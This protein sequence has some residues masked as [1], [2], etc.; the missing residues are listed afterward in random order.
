VSLGAYLR[1]ARFGFRRLPG[2]TVLCRVRDGERP[3]TFV[4]DLIDQDHR[5]EQ[6]RGRQPHVEFRCWWE[7][8]RGGQSIGYE[9]ADLV[10]KT[11]AGGRRV[12]TLRRPV[13]I[14]FTDEGEPI[15]ETVMP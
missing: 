7:Q 4:L 12:T 13:S 5:L 6:E 3:A 11:L 10:N 2:L 9:L 14:I 1:A 8:E 15:A